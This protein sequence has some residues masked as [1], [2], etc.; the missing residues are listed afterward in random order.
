MLVHDD[1]I[2]VGAN[3]H[4]YRLL[5]SVERSAAKDLFDDSIGYQ[6]DRRGLD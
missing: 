6:G 5:D 1:H 2:G 4:L 3:Y